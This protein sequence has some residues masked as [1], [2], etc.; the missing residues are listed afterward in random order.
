M[1]RKYL[2][3]YKFR[4]AAYLAIIIAANVAYSKLVV[5][6]G[7]TFDALKAGAL[8]TVIRL[9]ALLFFAL[10]FIRVV[11]YCADALS[12]H[13]IHRIRRDMKNSL[14]DGEFFDGGDVGT[15]KDSGEYVSEFT[16]EI[17]MVES[18]GLNSLKDISAHIVTIITMGS[19]LFSIDARMLVPV[20]AGIVLCVCIPILAGKNTSQRMDRFFRSYRSFVQTLG[21]F[22]SAF[23]MMKNFSLEDRIKARFNGKN[24]DLE[25]KKL[26]AETRITTINALIETSTWLML[27][28]V[29]LLGYAGIRRGALTLGS[30][31]TAYTLASALRS[32]MQNIVRCYNEIL[33]VRGVEQRLRDAAEASE[34][35]QAG[36]LSARIS[37]SVPEIIL[38]N[39]CVSLDGQRLLDEISVRFEPGKKYLILGE[40][41]SGKSCLLKTIK[42]ML[43]PDSGSI[44]I[45]G[46]DISEL[47]R[48]TLNAHISYSNE[49][50]SLFCDTVENNVCLYKPVPP[51]REEKAIREAHLALPAEKLI[52]DGG[53]FISSGEKRRLELARVFAGN[54]TVLLLDEVISTLDAVTAYEIEKQVLLIPGLTVIMVSNAFSGLLLDQ[55]DCIL[56]MDKGRISAAGT[57]SFLLETSDAYRTIYEIRCGFPEGGTGSC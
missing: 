33:S 21:D 47:S 23:Q 6:V 56:L 46:T 26:S 9:F 1:L 41:G 30:V 38:E 13:T 35:R 37:E 11:E 54:Q 49:T 10:L 51:E 19:T 20:A 2:F 25:N 7:V 29:I 28:A 3:Q 18:K 45:G 40:N 24:T 8:Q 57:H 14:F 36:D 5:N 32:P 53:S 42:K 17:A 50:V 48:E 39:V 22:F 55:Y 31:I 34:Q 44:R 4:V 12:I 16:N 43:L 15:G 52:G 27:L